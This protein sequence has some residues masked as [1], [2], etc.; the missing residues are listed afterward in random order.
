MASLTNPGVFIQVLVDEDTKN[1]KYKDAIYFTA[2][3][4]NALSNAEVRQ[5]ARDRAKVW[6]DIVDSTVQ[7]RPKRSEVQA[8][9]DMLQQQLAQADVDLVVADAD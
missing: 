4:Y 5:I 7:R 9:K 1:G 2:S 3:Q 8:R 6:S